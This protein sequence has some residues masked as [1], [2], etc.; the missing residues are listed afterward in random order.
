MLASSLNGLEGLAI[1][2]FLLLVLPLML[3]LLL[4]MLGIVIALISKGPHQSSRFLGYGAMLIGVLTFIPIF[5]RF[6]VLTTILRPGA[7]FDVV[8]LLPSI[9]CAALGLLSVKLWSRKK[10]A[11]M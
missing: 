8:Y 7:I 3:G 9:A 11:S 2:M 6:F 5:Y 10:R 1:L 4:G